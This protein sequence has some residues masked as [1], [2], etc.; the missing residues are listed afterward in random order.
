MTCVVDTD[1]ASF[2]FKDDTR[3]ALYR[4]HTADR[5]AVISFMALAE[6]ERWALS[7]GWGERRKQELERHLRRYSVAHSSPASCRV[8]AEVMDGSRRAGRPI[9]V[10]DA[11]HAATALLLDLPL[12]IHN[13]SHFANVTNLTIISEAPQKS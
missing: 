12:V 2:I 4:P 13:R 10:A 6:L 3:A 11:W 8:W 1:V 7:A 9:A 5:I